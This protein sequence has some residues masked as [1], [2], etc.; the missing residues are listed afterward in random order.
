[1]DP[2]L[3]FIYEATYKNTAGPNPVNWGMTSVDEMMAMGFHFI[4]GNDL[5]TGIK[6][7]VAKDEPLMKVIPNP[8]RSQ[9]VLIYELGQNENVQADLFNLLGEKMAVLIS[10]S[11]DKGKHSQTFR[12]ADYGLHTGVYF[13]NV[14][15]GN[16]TSCE[17]IIITD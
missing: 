8:S 10:G 4:Y 5:T 15:A 11:Q 13:L 17:K 7:N 14:R 9:F 2:R 16:K 12:A 1:V 6:D 3:G